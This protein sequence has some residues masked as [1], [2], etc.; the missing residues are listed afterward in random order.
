MRIPHTNGVLLN[1]LEA[2]SGKGD[3]AALRIL[4]KIG[5]ILAGENAVFD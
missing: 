2:N 5:F 1:R 3:E 4:L